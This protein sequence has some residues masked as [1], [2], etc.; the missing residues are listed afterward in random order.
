MKKFPVTLTFL[1]CLSIL[2]LSA[3]QGKETAISS[4]GLSS[5]QDGQLETTAPDKSNASEDAVTPSP[6]KRFLDALVAGDAPVIAMYLAAEEPVGR[7]IA[8]RVQVT[9]YT[10]TETDVPEQ[11]YVHLK[12]G[13]SE[14][15][16]FP[17][18]ESDWLLDTSDWTF[19]CF[20]HPI[21]KTPHRLDPKQGDAAP[22]AALG[23]LFSV[24]FDSEKDVYKSAAFPETAALWAEE[25][26]DSF[27]QASLRLYYSLLNMQQPPASGSTE[28]KRTDL[29]NC[30]RKTFGITPPDIR[31]CAHYDPKT[32]TIELAFVG[33]N[34]RFASLDAQ[35]RNGNLVTSDITYYADSAM[36]VEALSMRYVVE[37]TAV[38]PRLRSCELLRS[39]GLAPARGTT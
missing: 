23:Y 29:E 34:W 15:A 17:T 32:D 27:V 21:G 4:S 28:Q 10:M 22:E 1:S 36:L 7:H 6:A 18:G 2:L 19:G 14:L 31:Q 12:I 30:I 5:P 13:K 11:Y 37:K 35:L 38:G 20:F 25:D 3:C 16:V 8:D 9:S 26:S 24:A 39:N 33:D